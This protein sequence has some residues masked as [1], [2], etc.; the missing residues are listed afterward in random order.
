[1][2]TQIYSSAVV[3]GINIVDVAVP[4]FPALRHGDELKLNII[5]A[6]VV[7]SIVGKYDWM[8]RKRQKPKTSAKRLRD[9]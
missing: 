5:T 7:A 3:K 6:R 9:R 4:Q 1:M 2:E 8:R